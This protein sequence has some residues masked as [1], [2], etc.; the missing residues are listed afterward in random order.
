MPLVET[1]SVS[2]DVLESQGT[3]IDISLQIHN[4]FDWV[5]IQQNDSEIGP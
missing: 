3:G 4:D 5:S 1:M 2:P